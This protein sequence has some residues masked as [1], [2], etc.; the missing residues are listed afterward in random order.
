M[1]SAASA[2]DA[3]TVRAAV[4]PTPDPVATVA[5][6]SVT[7]RRNGRDVHALRGVSLAIAPGEILGLVG[8]SGSGKSVLGFTLLGL[9][10]KGAK[11]DGTVSVTGSDM[12]NGNAKALR[13]VRRLDL[14]AVFQ[15]PMTSLNPTMRIGKQVAEAAGSDEEALRLLTAVGIPE[16]KRRMRAYPHELSGG[17]RQRVM[18]AIAIAGDPE[19]I[20][21][22]EPTTALDVTVQAQVLRLLRRL[23]D[24]LGCSIVLITHDLGV[25]AQI[26]DRIAVLYAGR[27]AELGPSA[28]V[29]GAPAHPYT[30]GLL[31]SRLT[32][33]TA[34]DRRL[35]A[36]AGSVPSAVDPLPGCAFVPRCAL[37]ADDCAVTPP[38]TVVVG[39]ARVSACIRAVDDIAK[40][41]GAAPTNTDEAVLTPAT[42]AAGDAPPPS[43]VLQDVTKTFTVTRRWLDRSSDNHGKLHA[44]RGVTLRVGH[45]ESVALVGESGSGKSTLLRVIAGLEKPT[46][47]AVELADGE[48]PQMVFQD[49][50]ASL[51][52]WLS[53]GELIGERLHGM[54][55]AQRRDTVV[56]ALERV[57]LPAELAKSRAGQLSGGQ[58]QRVS[59]AR[60]TVVPPSVLLCDE[61]TSALD[62][63]L[64]ASVLNLIGD[65][66]RTL[67]MSV[68]FVTHDLSVARVVA[69]RIAVMYL[70]RIVELGPAEQVI[71]APAHP[72][73]E[74]LVDSIPDLGRES[75]ILPGEPASP[76]SP[77]TGCAFHPRCAIAVDTC[78]GD[79][80]DVR[81]EG[82]PGNPH[83][84][85]CIERRAV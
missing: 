22:D 45:G 2:V 59:L 55:R 79:E 58:R 11:V 69:D 4:P 23:R 66:R 24:E 7:F 34:R 57:G 76:L 56:G 75:R 61:P 72:Y 77:P 67:D 42:P 31:R 53:V 46:G 14:G 47:G 13:K 78:S 81:L 54:S 74:A 38:E 8:E 73:T 16:P 6:L 15:D 17:L 18:I 51:T 41:L 62:V 1:G 26:A 25:A 30:H 21:A 65:L 40:D 84:V 50:G 3:P 32:L 37:A 83:Q 28:E 19:L 5:D 43:V 60:A 85:A 9:L 68:V 70:G 12:V 36:L 33:E 52:P 82:M 39:P 44:L 64:A 48:R 71:A 27:M 10:P 49:A 35:A 80:L 29:L 63:S 20:V